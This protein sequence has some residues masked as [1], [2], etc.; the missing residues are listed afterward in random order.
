MYAKER[1]LPLFLDHIIQSIYHLDIFEAF[2]MLLLRIVSFAL[3][4]AE[5]SLSSFFNVLAVGRLLAGTLTNLAHPPLLFISL[6][7]ILLMLIAFTS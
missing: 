2:C 1:Y 7:N 4:C 3:T 6:L 5:I